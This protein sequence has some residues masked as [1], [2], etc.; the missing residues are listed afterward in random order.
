MNTL[1]LET[2]LESPEFF[3]ETIRA[4]FARWGKLARDIAFKPL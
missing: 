1:G 3:S 4:D 2:H